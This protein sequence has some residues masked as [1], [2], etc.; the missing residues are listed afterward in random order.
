MVNIF[1]FAQTVKIAG[2]MA[3]ITMSE[4]DYFFG[5]ILRNVEKIFE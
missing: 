1:N 3:K 5:E 4:K 2:T